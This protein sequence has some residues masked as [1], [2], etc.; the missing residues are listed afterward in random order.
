MRKFMW[1]CAIHG[2][3][4]RY[5]GKPSHHKPLIPRR[6]KPGSTSAAKV[7]VAARA[8]IRSIMIAMTLAAHRRAVLLFVF[9]VIVILPRPARADDAASQPATQPIFTRR[10]D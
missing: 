7:N 2:S 6:A 8:A 5:F 10:A 1:C 3:A 4:R 9:A